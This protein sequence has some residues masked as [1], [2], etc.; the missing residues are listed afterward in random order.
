VGKPRASLLVL[1]ALPGCWTRNLAVAGWS[2]EL[3]LGETGHAA[4]PGTRS[5]HP[6]VRSICISQQLNRWQQ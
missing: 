4:Y 6:V 1:R 5:D 3:D 2:R